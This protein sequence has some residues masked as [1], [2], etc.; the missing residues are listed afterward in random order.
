MQSNGKKLNIGIFVSHIG[1]FVH[2]ACAG[3]AHAAD[4][5]GANS[6]IFCLIPVIE[7]RQSVI[8][9][10]GAYRA[11][12]SSLRKTLSLISSFNLDALV[13]NTDVASF[14]NEAILEEFIASHPELPVAT[15]A[16]EL[17]GA[18]LVKTDNYTSTVKVVEHVILTHKKKNV[19]YISGPLDNVEA[20]ER[21]TAY[22][23]CLEK[24]GLEFNPDIVSEGDW[25]QESGR[26]GVSNI[27][28]ENKGSFDALVGG[29]D[30]IAFG[31]ID[32]LRSRGL[33]VP[34]D[35]TVMGF[36]NTT[37]AQTY[38]FSSIEQSYFELASTAV[39][40]LV[41]RI[42]GKRSEVK[43]VQ[44]P[45]KLVITKSCGC[46]DSQVSAPVVDDQFEKNKNSFE[47]LLLC[48]NN[49]DFNSP[50]LEAK[51]REDMYKIWKE[52]LSV[53][54]LFDLEPE[55][56]D[57]FKA[58]FA[59]VLQEHIQMNMSMEQWQ[60]ALLEVQ[61]SF[62]QLG[63]VD[64]KYDVY[65]GDLERLAC[66]AVARASRQHTLSTESMAYDSVVI[67]QRIMSA[68]D[69]S[70]VGEVYVDLM[71]RFRA[72]FAYMAT[73][74]R[75]NQKTGALKSASLISKIDGD[76][77]EMFAPDECH[78]QL[79]DFSEITPVTQNTEGNKHTHLLVIPIGINQDIY[80]FCVSDVSHDKHHWHL[81]RSMQIY[82]SQAFINIERLEINR[83]SEAEAKKATRTKSEFL[84]NMS[85]EIRTPLNAITGFAFLTQQ[86]DLSGQ[87]RDY[88]KKITRASETLLGVIN[89]ILDFSKIE[90]GHLEVE[91][92]NFHIDSVLEHLTDLVRARAEEKDLQVFIV[93]DADIPTEIIGDP[94]RLGQVLIN[95]A[96]NAVKF[97]EK[98]EV[99]ISVTKKSVSAN[100]CELTFTVSDT[101]I[102]MSQ[103]QTERLFLPFSQAD[104]STTRRFGGTGLGL[105]ISRQLVEL[106]GGTINVKSVINQGSEF[107]CSIPFELPNEWSTV[108]E[109]YL[110]VVGKS[111]LVV[112]DNSTSRKVMSTMLV[113]FGMDVDIAKDGREAYKAVK[114]VR[115]SQRIKPYDLVLM[116]WKMPVMDGIESCNK[117]LELDSNCPTPSI[118]MMTAH[119][120]EE[121]QSQFP[122]ENK[123]NVLV[124]P[125]SPAALVKA[126]SDALNEHKDTA[127][128]ESGSKFELKRNIAI[129]RS[130]LL[131]E[132]NPINQQIATELLEIQ[133]CSVHVANNGIEA[134]QA[135]I[136]MR[137]DLVFMD[138]QMPQM[139][140][141][142][143]TRT[144]RQ[145]PTGKITPIIAMTAHAMKT[146]IAKCLDSG[147][148]DH[149]AKPI[150]PKLLQSMLTKHLGIE[151]QTI[152][153]TE[154]GYA[155]SEDVAQLKVHLVDIDVESGLARVAGKLDLYILLLKKFVSEQHG[156]ISRIDAL[157]KNHDFQAVARIAHNIKGAAANLGMD[158]LSDIASTLQDTFGVNN[159]DLDAIEKLYKVME[160]LKPRIDTLQ[161]TEPPLECS[162]AGAGK[163]DIAEILNELEQK[164]LQGST[165]SIELV[166][167]LYCLT[168]EK[169]RRD[170]AEIGS[171]VKEFEFEKA[172][173]ELDKLKSS[174]GLLIGERND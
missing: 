49:V 35:I 17:K 62:K 93:H 59:Q 116:D 132:D 11:D 16:S 45:G 78:L 58:L 110:D 14:A 141:F 114:T 79:E 129:G 63:Y 102:G 174:M 101:G 125:V 71:S 135:M 51:F 48:L 152:I 77:T 90:A 115:S 160:E 19:A 40:E 43:T 46:S 122:N 131:V 169:Y 4:N 172:M 96:S 142:E 166:E 118:V 170:L 28:D 27:L 121:L 123:P 137:F 138:I 143:A 108:S 103:S 65:F 73:F 148:S 171:Q 20:V 126:V 36:D 164:L 95:L 68:E 64:T 22:K 39:E 99:T 61:L 5:L 69:L 74:P 161:V 30:N 38:D 156:N 7:D 54:R 120:R 94:L 107:I 167:Q 13:I 3:V 8:S 112:D 2:P 146:E 98:G 83:R 97:T 157:L 140:G 136:E 72:S 165:K 75:E 55:R 37:Q 145:L 12:D 117:I 24:H 162:S 56:Q 44:C 109:N 173:D 23:D 1:D 50:R 41:W 119:D 147:M 100:Q 67:G 6:Q 18:T 57:T 139:D 89:D 154:Q 66:G 127:G 134:V 70:R 53:I 163:P 29:N 91:K 76:K 15:I 25:F 52:L 47:N 88:I 92:V 106:M 111:V 32:E 168:D 86:T 133:G 21:F 149:I 144:I 81:Y 10:A 155:S 113:S 82:L 33:R 60:I 26:K 31:A 158:E 34:G 151:D 150:N 80:G 9:D 159:V 130:I 124:K 84:A 153:S 87:Q 85:H 42:R 104:T 105:A 128:E